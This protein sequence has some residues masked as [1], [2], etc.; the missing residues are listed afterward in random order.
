[1]FFAFC[2]LICYENLP[3]IE[4]V[5]LTSWWMGVVTQIPWDP[6][7]GW[8][9]RPHA[10]NL[11]TLGRL[12]TCF[13]HARPGCK[14]SRTAWP[15]PLSPLPWNTFTMGVWEA[16]W[17]LVTMRPH[18]MVKKRTALGMKKTNVLVPVRTLI[19]YC[20]QASLFKSVLTISFINMLMIIYHTRLILIRWYLKALSKQWNNIHK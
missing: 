14:P 8:S 19:S 13:L 5:R 18:D 4:G 16:V 20:L 9:L 17:L 7:S 2:V 15:T 6:V 11:V 3:K 10:L 12:R 1:M